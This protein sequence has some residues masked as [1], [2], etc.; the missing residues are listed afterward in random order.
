MLISVTI[1]DNALISTRF[2]R[3]MIVTIAGELNKLGQTQLDDHWEIP[4]SSKRRL[5]WHR[6]TTITWNDCKSVHQ[7]V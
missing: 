5:K 6:Y 3:L 4:S 1:I 7:R 2:V